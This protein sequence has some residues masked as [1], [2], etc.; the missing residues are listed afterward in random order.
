MEISNYA[1][2]GD[3]YQLYIIWS[4]SCDGVA[5]SNFYMLVTSCC[6]SYGIVWN[7]MAHQVSWISDAVKLRVMN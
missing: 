4:N 3:S 6:T 7:K 5:S 1:T 2:V